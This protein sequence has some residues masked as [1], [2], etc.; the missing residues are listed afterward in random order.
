MQ[1]H[2]HGTQKVVIQS[3]ER[4]GLMD[5][6]KHILSSFLDGIYQR[7]R[8][9]PQLFGLSTGVVSTYSDLAVKVIKYQGLFANNTSVSV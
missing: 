2:L 4:N 3:W 5:N 7:R 6:K 1:S 8:Y 9:S